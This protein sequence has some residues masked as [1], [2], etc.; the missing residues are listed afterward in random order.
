MQYVDIDG[1]DT[2]FNSSMAELTLPM[3]NVALP[4]VR[5]LFMLV[6]IG[7]AKL[8]MG[9]A[10]ILLMSQRTLIAQ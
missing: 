9:P 10:R 5:I 6:F 3:E 7:P 1:V 2:T 8:M 4:N